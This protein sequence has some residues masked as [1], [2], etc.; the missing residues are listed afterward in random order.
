[1]TM[2]A[3]T[4]LSDFRGQRV[5]FQLENIQ[6]LSTPHHT[7]YCIVPAAS[8]SL[9]S[10]ATYQVHEAVPRR[11]DTPWNLRSLTFEVHETLYTNV[12]VPALS[13]AQF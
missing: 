13:V 12:R 11:H 2:F 7:C 4:C 8:L 6:Y 10:Q 1:M 9:Q 3:A 5:R